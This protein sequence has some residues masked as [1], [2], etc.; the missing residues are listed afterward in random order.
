M[1]TKFR[2]LM[3]FHTLLARQLIFLSI[4]LVLGA[5]G[6]KPAVSNNDNAQIVVTPPA[7]MTSSSAATESL[8]LVSPPILT[9]LP[10]LAVT[11]KPTESPTS[12]TC[13]SSELYRITKTPVSWLQW[14]ATGKQLFYKLKNSGEYWELNTENNTTTPLS[15]EQVI[16]LLVT[17]DNNTFNVP[18]SIQPHEYAL[19]PSRRKVIY[20]QRQDLTS[21]PTPDSSG[22]SQGPLEIRYD[23]FILET[24]N[25]NLA[26]LG[27]IDGLISNLVWFPNEEGVLIQT[28]ARLPG[29]ASIWLA[30]LRN[31]QLVPLVLVKQGEPEAAFE[32]LSP[33]GNSILYRRSTTL[34]VIHLVDGSEEEVPLATFGR[35]YYW[36]LSANKLLIVDDFDLPLDFQV[37]VFD[38][39]TKEL[40]RISQQT[41][42]IH[43]VELSPN[44]D[45]LAIQWDKTL[46]LYILPLC[47]VCDQGY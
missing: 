39:D 37:A 13:D 2:E 28:S 19:S 4:L 36:F 11:I 3:A 35:A 17:P 8:S 46:E 18:K 27:D 33:D 34:Y 47:P 15:Q 25:G 31:Q 5:C 12:L 20:A 41:L 40:C 44:Y 45:Y 23:L 26:L 9:E 43:S 16:S 32:A 24:E 22:E 38:L 42:Q 6:I 29:T 21:T 14:S 1:S 30:D 10:T 7:I